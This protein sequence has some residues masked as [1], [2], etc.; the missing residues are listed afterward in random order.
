M[1]DGPARALAEKAH[2]VLIKRDDY[3]RVGK[4][5]L[6]N[7]GFF[8][9]A[10]ELNYN[11]SILCNYIPKL[12]MRHRGYTRADHIYIN[13]KKA[14][15]KE[16][17]KVVNNYNALRL[18]NDEGIIVLVA[19]HSIPGYSTCGHVAIVYPDINEKDFLNLKIIQAG[20]FNDIFPLI[21]AFPTA[22]RN[23]VTEPILYDL[24]NLKLERWVSA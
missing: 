19:S 2:D 4:R 1:N 10:E 17:I 18:T 22:G 3:K 16:I 20:W 15:N 23:K 8:T 13:A 11:I 21:Q 14:A 9:V 6:C 7:Q 24:S 12:K 5:T